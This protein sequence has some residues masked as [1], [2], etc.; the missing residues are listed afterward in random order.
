[1]LGKEKL[2]AVT[3]DCEGLLLGTWVGD[4]VGDTVGDADEGVDVGYERWR[5]NENIL[6]WQ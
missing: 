4:T 6:V 2:T 1:M 5:D 3:G